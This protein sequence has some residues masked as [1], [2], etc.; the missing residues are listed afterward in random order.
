M[1]HL[2][3]YKAMELLNEFPNEWRTISSINRRMKKLRDIGTNDR[4]TESGRPRSA[5]HKKMLTWLTIW[6]W[7]KK[8]RMHCCHRTVR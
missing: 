7:V 6:F 8:I 5:P 2:K 1:Y 4:L 3:R